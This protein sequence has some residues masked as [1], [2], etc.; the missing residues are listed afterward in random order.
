MVNLKWSENKEDG[1]FKTVEQKN[2]YSKSIN[3]SEYFKFVACP[4]NKAMQG[5]WIPLKL[6]G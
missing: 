2:L 4:G 3:V 5:A 1:C 6:F